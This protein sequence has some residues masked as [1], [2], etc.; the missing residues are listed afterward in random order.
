MK[1]VVLTF[2]AL[3][4]LHEFIVVLLLGE[5]AATAA[6]AAVVSQQAT[7]G[8]D[9]DDVTEGLYEVLPPKRYHFIK[10]MHIENLKYCPTQK[11]KKVSTVGRKY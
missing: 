10:T 11:T 2:E 5:W 9:G 6:C 7:I 3:P 1:I 8:G 4:F